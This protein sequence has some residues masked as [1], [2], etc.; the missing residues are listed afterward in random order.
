MYL[1]NGEYGCPSTTTTT[2][3]KEGGGRRVDLAALGNVTLGLL[4]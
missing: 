4:L 1:A 2:R 3:A